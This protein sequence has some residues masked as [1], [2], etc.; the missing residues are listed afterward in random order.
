MSKS[1]KFVL[2]ALVGAVAAALLTP[3]SGKKA[4]DKVKH[5]ASKAGL[6][7]NKI[8]KRVHSLA[9]KGAEALGSLAAA[10]KSEVQETKT[11]NKRK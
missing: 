10:A 8:E 3:V 2:G 9:K 11:K 6:D 1:S 7:A 5:T 4:R